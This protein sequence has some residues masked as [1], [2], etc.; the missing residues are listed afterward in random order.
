M[1]LPAEPED[2]VHL[3]VE[4]EPVTNLPVLDGEAEEFRWRSLRA[5]HRATLPAWLV[6]DD[7]RPVLDAQP[8]N[9]VDEDPGSTNAASPSDR[10]LPRAVSETIHMTWT[11]AERP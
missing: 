4:V 10:A 6:E 7:R 11:T 9:M 8:G 2:V 3:V 5:G 1:V